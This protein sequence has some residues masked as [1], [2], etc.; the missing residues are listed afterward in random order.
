MNKP[1]GGVRGWIESVFGTSHKAISENLSAEDY[2]SFVADAEKLQATDET[3]DEDSEEQDE[4]DPDPQ[5][6]DPQNKSIE[7]RISA[8]EKGLATANA[9]LKAE[10]K[11]SKDLQSKLTAAETKLTE[12]QTKLSV[13]EA[14]KKK[15]RDAVNPLGEDLS[16]DN[17][18][19][20]YLTKADIDAR[21]SY[22][23]NR[24]E[25]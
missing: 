14:Q 9:A 17:P 8:L 16:D 21:E 20:E 18:K 22:K 2:N 15:L 12:T 13:S 5:N 25:E 23:K 19:D 6:I 7:D 24:S 4:S 11:V 10:K 3:D 1:K